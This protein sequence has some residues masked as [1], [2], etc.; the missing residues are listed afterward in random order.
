[1]SDEPRT[2]SWAPGQH[3]PTAVRPRLVPLP[4][5]GTV[6]GHRFV[7]E[8]VLGKGGTSVVYVARDGRLGQSVAIKLLHPDLV[9]DVS[10]ERLRREVQAARHGHA[11]VVTVYDLHDDG[12]PMPYLSMELV[13]G[14]SLAHILGE[15]RHRLGIEETIGIGR[16]IAAALDHLHAH[17]L[18]HRD[19]KPSNI[20]ITESGVAKLCDLG[21]VRLLERGETLT[22]TAMTVGTP[23][24]MAPEQG[25]GGEL[26]PAADVYALGLTLYE[27]LTGKV[28]H[29][30]DTAIDTLVRRQ[31]ARPPALRRD[32]P[33]CPRWLER[34]LARTLD[35]RPAD[36]PSAI[37]VARAL[38]TRRVRRRVSRRAM[39]TATAL[40]MLAGASALTLRALAHRETVRVEA[41]GTEVRGVDARGQATWKIPLVGPVETVEHADIDGDGSEEVLVGTAPADRQDAWL[42][43]ASYGRQEFL[44]V[45]KSGHVITRV[46]PR[47]VL[48]L[49][50]GHP[51]QPLFLIRSSLERRQ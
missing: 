28:P 36:R 5:P 19:V 10:R 45:A 24:Y 23:A 37:A 18:V 27:C 40:I 14:R 42:G 49:R 31:K 46:D 30:G 9:N 34:L 3:T 41:A 33:A 26:T 44:I 8:A 29:A 48:L 47:D 20:L 12:G 21:L 13:E 43:A 11:N 6:L 25:S 38:E 15:E 16:Q 50:W 22:A 1:M 35:P 2:G 7:I 4:E 39:A 32:D 17:G 51:F